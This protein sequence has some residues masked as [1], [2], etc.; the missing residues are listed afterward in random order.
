MLPSEFIR[1][2]NLQLTENEL[3]LSKKAVEMM[4]T[5]RDVHHNESHA[6]RL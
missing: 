3:E 1:K 5:G 4:V 2:Y 6:Y